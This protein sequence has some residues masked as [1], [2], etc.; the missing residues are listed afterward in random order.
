MPALGAV[1]PRDSVGEDA[2]VQVSVDGFFDR[3][4]EVPVGPLEAVFV[5]PEKA[6]EFGRERPIEHRALGPAGAVEAGAR[7]G[8]G[9]LLCA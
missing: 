6:L 4:S 5:D 9:H 3:S 8:G 2:A 1:R 7:S